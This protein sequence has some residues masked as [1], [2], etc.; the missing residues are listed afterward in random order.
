MVYEFNNLKKLVL[1]SASPRRIELLAQV[2]IAPDVVD[3]SA[4]IENQEGNERPSQMVARLSES[5]AV[6]V[7]KRHP[8]SFV[9]AADTAVAVGRRVLGKPIN[10]EQAREF[11][12]I[13]S[14]RRHKVLTGVALVTPVGKTVKRI[15][16]TSV[17]FKRLSPRDFDNYLE[18]R[19]W[20]GKAGGYAIQGHAGAFACSIS[21]SYTNI[22]GLPLCET[23]NMLLGNGFCYQNGK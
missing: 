19:E 20:R 16:T 4:I 6:E 18:L 14:G 22:V 17:K 9:L 13:L 12:V 21:G 23:V 8:S 2:G 7:A 1:A 3:P 10:A 15:V 11:L 5:K